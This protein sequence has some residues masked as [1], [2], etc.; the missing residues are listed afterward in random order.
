M[1]STL[2]R[3][4]EQKRREEKRDD[5]GIGSTMVDVIA[6]AAEVGS[7]TTRATIERA[8]PTPTPHDAT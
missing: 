4:K 1:Q 5:Y 2:G 7:A 6:R 8:S 3:E